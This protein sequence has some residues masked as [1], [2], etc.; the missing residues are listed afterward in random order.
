MKWVKLVERNLNWF[1]PSLAVLWFVKVKWKNTQIEKEIYPLLFS[2]ALS[3]PWF[4]EILHL[5]KCS[6]SFLLCYDLNMNQKK[7]E[8]QS[9]YIQIHSR[10]DHAHLL[11][12]R[13]QQILLKWWKT[14]QKGVA[15]VL[16][17]WAVC[18]L[19]NNLCY[20]G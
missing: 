5:S 7:G 18:S 17:I 8:I 13:D 12:Y 11:V 15:T 20:A 3:E 2:L 1:L 9:D 10:L 19:Y 6:V 4:K 16:K 14:N